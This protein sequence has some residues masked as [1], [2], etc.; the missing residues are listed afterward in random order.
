M[1]IFVE[2][3]AH[4]LEFVQVSELSLLVIHDHFFFFFDGF[5]DLFHLAVKVDMHALDVISLC[6]EAKQPK[7]LFLFFFEINCF[8]AF[9]HAAWW[10]R[11]KAEEVTE[12]IRSLGFFQI[13]SGSVSTSNLVTLWRRLLLQRLLNKFSLSNNMLGSSSIDNGLSLLLV[14]SWRHHALGNSILP[15]L[16]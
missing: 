2:V 10:V 11:T 16:S 6:F 15:E 9:A 13:L 5:H 1:M 14:S 4:V 8:S 7:E 3:L 12:D